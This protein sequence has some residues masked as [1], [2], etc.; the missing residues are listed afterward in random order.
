MQI[1][2]DAL[3]GV[4][5]VRNVFATI[6][7]T[8]L[9]PWVTNMGLTNVTIISVVLGLALSLLF[10]PMIIWGKRARIWTADRLEVMAARQYVS[11]RD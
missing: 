4:I 1:I 2:G 5:F 8:T 10:V 6:I 11:R 9:T 3:I 7:A